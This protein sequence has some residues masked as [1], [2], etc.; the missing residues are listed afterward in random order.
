[1]IRCFSLID[2]GN[3]TS[4]NKNWTSLLQSISLYSDFEV[5][6]YPK[7]IYRDIDG[8]NFGESYSGFHNVWIFD[9]ED[10]K[11]T[12]TSELE[13]IINHVPI[14]CGLNES[15]KIPLKV[16]LTDTINKNISLLLM[17][18]TIK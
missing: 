17:K 9:F 10:N 12:D 11:T 2:L 4:I 16:I 15:I 18:S 3:E 1:M 6:V 7:K 5:L 8:L 14:I 13:K